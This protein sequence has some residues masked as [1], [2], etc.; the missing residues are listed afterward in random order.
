MQTEEDSWLAGRLATSDCEAL[1]FMP[2]RVGTTVSVQVKIELDLCACK[3]V[4]VFEG[5]FI[6]RWGTD[7][8]TEPTKPPAR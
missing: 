6:V 2:S 8:S 4:F 1:S 3:I 5:Q 7:S